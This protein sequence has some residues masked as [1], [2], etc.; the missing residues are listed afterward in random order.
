MI[1]EIERRIRLSEMVDRQKLELIFEDHKMTDFKWIAPGK[2]VV[3]RWVRMKCMFGCPGYG[4]HAA[5][6]PNVPTV[7]E[8]E[9]FF[10]EYREAAVFRFSKTLDDPEDRHEWMQTIN[11][12]ML[13][14]EKQIFISGHEKAFLL[15]ASDC[16][17][18]EECSVARD[19]CAHPRQG[20]PTAEALGVDV[21]STVRSVGYP[22]R[23]LADYSQEMNRYAFIMIA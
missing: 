21:Y 14:L 4:K 17:I 12:R 2:F 11:A 6:P 23:V 18:C 3:A 22:I 13:E 7:A 5:C 8:C 16:A 15:V 10:S 20:R 9:K 1:Y 19:M